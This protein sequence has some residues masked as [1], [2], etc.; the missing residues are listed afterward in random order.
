MSARGSSFPRSMPDARCGETLGTPLGADGR[1]E[2]CDVLRKGMPA[3]IWVGGRGTNA[4]LSPGI[5]RGSGGRVMSGG[6]SVTLIA[7]DGLTVVALE[8]EHDVE[9]ADAIRDAI[10]DSVEQGNVVV[11]LSKTTFADSTVLRSLLDGAN[12]AGLASSAFTLLVP[13]SASLAVRRVIELTQ[14]GDAI[15]VVSALGDARSGAPT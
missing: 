3:H 13:E 5:A 8:G 4:V 15:R 10:V 7:E 9:T 6:G 12:A 14:L 11:D 2:V 1:G